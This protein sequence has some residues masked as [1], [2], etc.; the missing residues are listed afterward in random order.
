MNIV[1]IKK[2][3]SSIMHI[4]KYLIPDLIAFKK[5]ISTVL[6]I[7]EEVVFTDNE[8]ELEF[9]KFSEKYDDPK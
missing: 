5:T 1:I 3:I 9:C 2:E 4:P 6:D 7:T 8:S